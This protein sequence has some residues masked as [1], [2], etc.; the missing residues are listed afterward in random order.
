M[1]AKVSTNRAERTPNLQNEINRAK[2]KHTVSTALNYRNILLSVIVMTLPEMC[3]SDTYEEW[4]LIY[5]AFSVT[6]LISKC[7]CSTAQLVPCCLPFLPL[8]LNKLVL[9]LIHTLPQHNKSSTSDYF[10]KKSCTLYKQNKYLLPA[11]CYLPFNICGCL[12]C[13]KPTPLIQ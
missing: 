10:E 11:V 8:W 4:W 7:L 5:L 12:I 1:A 9:L 6:V 2:Q 13:I 3:C